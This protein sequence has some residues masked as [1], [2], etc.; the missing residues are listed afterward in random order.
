MHHGKHVRR[1]NRT[2][3]HRRALFR[4]LVSA[5]IKNER[6]ETTLPKA[7]ELKKIADKMI[8]IGKKGDFNAKRS[9]MA[10]LREHH[11]TIPILFDTL[12]PRFA[13]RNGGYTR[14]QRIGQ[15]YGDNAPMAVIEYI[16]GTFDLKKEIVKKEIAQVLS[17]ASGKPLPNLSVQDILAGKGETMGLSRKLQ[18][19]IKKVKASPNA[20]SLQGDIEAEIAKVSEQMSSTKL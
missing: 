8:T 16:D 13:N 3:A 18:R 10:Y 1:L 5:L 4:N 11:T 19:D 15:R 9:A 2:S 17:P 6:I 14:I 12:A 20:V 7:K